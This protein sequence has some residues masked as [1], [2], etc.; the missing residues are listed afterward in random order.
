V[1]DEISEL[2]I[3]A[4]AIAA[5]PWLRYRWES[6]EWQNVSMRRKSYVRLCMWAGLA[7]ASRHQKAEAKRS[8]L[9]AGGICAGAAADDSTL[10]RP[11]SARMFAEG[12]WRPRLR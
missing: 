9:L 10:S 5:W 8:S 11:G 7:A 12:H 3:E 2:D 1:Y 4:A 6:R